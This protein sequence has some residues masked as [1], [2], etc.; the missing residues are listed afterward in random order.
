MSDFHFY[1]FIPLILIVAVSACVTPDLPASKGLDVRVEA[2][3]DKLFPGG[4]LLLLIDVENK[5]EKTYRNIAIDVFDTGELIGRCQKS[6]Q[7]MRPQAIESLE[8]RLSVPAD[9]VKGQT[10]WTKVTFDSSLSASLQAEVIS[11]DE[12]DL[13]TKLGTLQ[14]QAKSYTFS[15]KN[16]QLTLDFDEAPPFV[17]GKKQFVR[18][19]VR[20]TGNGLVESIKPGDVS[21]QSSI[22]SCL[23][24]GELFPMGREFPTMVCEVNV[25]GVNYLSQSL[26]NIDIKY[27]Y[28]VREKIFIPK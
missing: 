25:P 17:P 7:Q 21:V 12:Y 4:R 2:S 23:P 18:L 15:D 24:K 10:A 1:Y 3:P 11:Q 27:S 20:N 28:D 9:I 13:R 6:A 14:R 5:D 8:C 16:M 26:I 19:K 22:V